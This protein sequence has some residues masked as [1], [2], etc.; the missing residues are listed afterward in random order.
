MFVGVESSSC[1]SQEDKLKGKPNFAVPLVP[2]EEEDT[3]KVGGVKLQQKKRGN[4]N[5]WKSS[6]DQWETLE[7]W[8]SLIGI[9]R[10]QRETMGN[11]VDL[12]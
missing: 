10:D 2:E 6:I 12:S 3:E 1:G 4:E 5:H 11:E 8:N 9:I 7:N